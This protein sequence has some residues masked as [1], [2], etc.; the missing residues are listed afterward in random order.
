MTHKSP[1]TPFPPRNPLSLT[2]IIGTSSP[3]IKGFVEKEVI[4]YGKI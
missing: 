3:V 4:N 1:K 2:H